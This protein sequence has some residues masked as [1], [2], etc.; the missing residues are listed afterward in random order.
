MVRILF[1]SNVLE[2]SIVG[3]AAIVNEPFYTS[4]FQVYSTRQLPDSLLNPIPR[5]MLF[6]T[7]GAVAT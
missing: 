5:I 1:A 4:G 2:D 7:T 3:W 6:Q